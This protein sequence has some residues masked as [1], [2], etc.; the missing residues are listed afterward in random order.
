MTNKLR[1]FFP[2]S[3]F[4]KIS[5]RFGE[6]ILNYTA[7]GLK[8]HTG[9]DIYQVPRS[10]YYSQFNIYAAH[11]GEVVHIERDPNLG[12]GVTLRTNEK[13][14][15]VNG[16]EYYWKTRYWHMQVKGV[17]V[18]IGQQVK[19]G[20]LIGYADSTGFS[21]GTHLHFDLKPI[22]IVGEID[23]EEVKRALNDREFTNVFFD[24]GYYG[25]VDLEPYLEKKSDGSFYTAN[26]LIK[27]LEKAKEEI[28]KTESLLQRLV[29]WFK[30][31]GRIK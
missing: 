11:D 9:F 21:T 6:N 2:V 26:Q 25:A 12:I 28:K 17:F 15:D 1:L 10:F 5:Q 19:A 13:F 18:Q 16:N 4:Y 22:K 29:A 3:E 24:N 7:F 8:G 23:T 27:D 31:I 20:E 14:S 30:K